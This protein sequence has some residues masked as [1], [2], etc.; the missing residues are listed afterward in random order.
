MKT[1]LDRPT[2]GQTDERTITIETLWLRYFVAKTQ[3]DSMIKKNIS[4]IN[5]K[6]K[7]F[8]KAGVSLADKNQSIQTLNEKV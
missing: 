8:I 5:T 7:I 6:R 2:D 4:Y 1:A 3:K